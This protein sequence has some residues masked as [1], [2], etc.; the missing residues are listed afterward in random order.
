[1]ITHTGTGDLS[2]SLAMSRHDQ[3]HVTRIGSRP[4]E[5]FARPT[6][7]AGAVIWRFAKDAAASAPSA[8]ESTDVEIAL[9]HRPRYDDWSLPKG[10]VDPGENLPGT[11]MREILEETGFEVRLGWLLGYVHYP[12]GSRTKVV[13]YWTA[14]HLSG[15]F[16]AN[17]ESDELRWVSPA[18]AKELLSYEADLKVVDA[19]L[20]LLQLGCDRRV[21]YVRHAKAHAR[22]GWAGDDDLRPLSKKGRRQAELLVSGL[23]GYR[24]EAISSAVPVRCEHTAAPIAEDLGL[25]VASDANLGDAGWAADSD[26]AVDAFHA[27]TTAPVSMVVGQGTVIPGVLARVAGEHGVEIEDMRVKKSSTWVLHFAGDKLLGLDYLASP[28]AVK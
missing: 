19:A 14:Q 16:E 17:D 22:E 3:G 26:A 18:E 6:F 7:A 1:M 21:L 27:A 5:E 4:S 2:T 15:E 20:G 25:D 8:P 9:I 23:S 13:Y 12:V 28:L 10:K 11:A 24:P